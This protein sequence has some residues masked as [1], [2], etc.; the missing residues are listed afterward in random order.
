[1]SIIYFQI[2]ENKNKCTKLIQQ[3]PLRNWW[4]ELSIEYQY[5]VNATNS[6]LFSF[7]SVYFCQIPFQLWQ[8]LKPGMKK[9]WI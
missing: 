2:T 4:L 9:H 3:K 1:M 7:V 6:S 5:L 8:A